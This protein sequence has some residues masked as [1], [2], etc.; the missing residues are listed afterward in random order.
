MDAFTLLQV[1][2]ELNNICLSIVF[3]GYILG[4]LTFVG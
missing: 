1:D 4:D 2:Q 3:I